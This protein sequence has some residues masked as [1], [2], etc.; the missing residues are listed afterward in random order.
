F[1]APITYASD[2]GEGYL[3]LLQQNKYIFTQDLP[4]DNYYDATMITMIALEMF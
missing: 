3:K 4:L 1:L 2:K